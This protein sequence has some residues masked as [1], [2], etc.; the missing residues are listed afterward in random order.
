LRVLV[1]TF[2]VAAFVT[3]AAAATANAAVLKGSVQDTSGGAVAEAT[4]MLACPGTARTTTA[5]ARGRFELRD[6]PASRCT[7]AASREHFSSALVDV[8]LSSNGEITARLVLPV[9][10]LDT[11]LVVTPAVGGPEHAADV[12]A[13]LSVVGG[14]EL[15]MRPATVL[16]DVLREEPGIVVQQTTAAA[17]SPIIRGFTGQSNVYLVDGVRLNTSMWRSGPVQYLAW[18]SAA[19]AERLEVVRGPMSVQ[20][21]SDALGG[22]INVISSR[23]GF[24]ARGIE[25]NGAFQSQIASANSSRGGDASVS[26]RGTRAALSIG[27]SRQSVGELRAGGG[28]DSHAAVT[29]YFGLPASTI[30]DRMR[31]TG[32][33][34]WGLQASGQVRTGRDGIF[35]GVYRSDRQTGVNRYDRINGGEGL[36]RSEIT[37]QRFDLGVL[38]YERASLGF[39]EGA[40]VTFSVNRQLD[41]T[42]EQ[43]RPTARIDSDRTGVTAYGYQAQVSR[44]FAG[45]IVTGGVERFDE[46]IDAGRWQTTGA[47]VTAIRPLIP[48]GTQYTSTGA[49]LQAASRDIFDRVSLRGGLRYNAYRYQ[50]DANSAFSIAAEDVTMNAV[51]FNAAA[52]IAITPSLRATA[53][54]GRG[55]RAANTADLGAVGVSGGGGFEIS[56]NVAAGLNA[57]I[58]TTDGTDAVSTSKRVSGLAPESEYAYEA[59][60]RY[61]GRHV[62]ASATLFDLELYDAISR[63]ALVFDTS[64]VGMIISGREIVRQDASGLAYIAIDPRPIGT[65]VN[66]S[67]GRIRGADLE[68]IVR[69]GPQWSA[70]TYF[71]MA[72]GRDLQTGA[73]LRRM[74]PPMGGLNVAWQRAPRGL[75]VEATMTYARTQT[76]LA[77]GDLT[78]ARIGGRRTTATIAS[79][80]NGTAT[81]IG[82]VR[83]G[84][85][86][87]T[88]ETLAQVQARVLGGAASG[89]LFADA[90]GFVTFGA[91]AMYPVTA[92]VDVIVVGENLT[93]RNY[94]LIGSGVDA[95]GVNLVAKIRFRF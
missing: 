29:R 34:Q 13:G 63:R 65:R 17:G 33:D 49:F 60:L 94:R 69:L 32:Y 28:G 10:T 21:G 48:D 31:G 61:N 50:T 37:P 24:S 27:G 91:R 22:A 76:R 41:G 52:S 7:V 70:R 74:N 51:T 73:F 35:S 42:V 66:S 30:A 64:V 95:P 67:R 26:I 93:D 5:D 9:E 83:N 44:R 55:F 53:S 78:D 72:N 54:V 25:I 2:G 18:L 6:L 82:L 86:V 1:R 15:R 16:P 45:N 84:I 19:G 57:I 11:S 77:S 62:S 46:T 3:L 68:G 59:G 71:S 56:P 43:A 87:P 75:R 38:R 90:P 92:T 39:L 47:T 12:P 40:R 80:F 81:D 89:L 36:F 4:I 88:G 20:Y 14:Q 58:G 23:P 8:D 79:Y 85:L